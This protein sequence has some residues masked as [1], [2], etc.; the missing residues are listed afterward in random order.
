MSAE[1]REQSGAWARA[2]RQ[3]EQ[4]EHWIGDK[5]IAD[6]TEAIL[7]AAFLSGGKNL[8]LRAASRLTV[9]LQDYAGLLKTTAAAPPSHSA[10]LR[11]E[12]REY[13]EHLLGRP[14]SKAHV[15]A[16]AFVRCMLFPSLHAEE[17]LY[18]P[19][20]WPQRAATCRTSGKQLISPPAEE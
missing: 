20:R 14:I 18:R 17:R 9:R 3:Q 13:V 10:L 5:T 6:V 15:I 19:T 1:R 8:V 11:L 12:S 2:K 4:T 16:Q 7:G